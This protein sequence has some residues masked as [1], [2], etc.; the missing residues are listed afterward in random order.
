MLFETG[1]DDRSLS[2]IDPAGVA[3][4]AIKELVRQNRELERSVEALK[5]EITQIRLDAMSK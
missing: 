3:L 2:T 5:R 1:G 4:A